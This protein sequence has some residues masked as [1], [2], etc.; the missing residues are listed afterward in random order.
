[1]H[2]LILILLLKLYFKSFATN[3]YLYIVEEIIWN[4][5]MLLP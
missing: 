4:K 2:I 5:E 3:I 1:M